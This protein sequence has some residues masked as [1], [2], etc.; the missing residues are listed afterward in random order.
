MKEKIKT[1]LGS[2]FKLSVMKLS[3]KV[4]YKEA[5]SDYK[6]IES[7]DFKTV[8][9]LHEAMPNSKSQIKQDLFVLYALNFKKNGFFVEFGAT[10]GLNLSNTHLL[11]TQ[12]GWNGILAEPAKTWHSA[13]QKNRECFIETNCVW[14]KSGE[15]LAFNEVE[16]PELSTVAAFNESDLHKQSRKSGESYLVNTISLL[17]LLKKY[18]APKIIDYLSIDTE[19]SEF[20]IL[21]NF[22]FNNY[23]FRV[24]TCEHNKTANR[25]KIYNLLTS[26]GYKRKFVGFSKFDDWYVKEDL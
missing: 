1:I 15:Q 25:E 13:L 9:R 5:F 8:E 14:K 24:I 17:D 10:N 4:L 6:E 22:D 21:Q 26:K 16:D 12:Y 19:G 23:G 11:E 7:I 18:N 3:S 20:E 2:L